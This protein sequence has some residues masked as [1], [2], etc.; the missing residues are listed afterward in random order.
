MVM[1]T[2]PF[3]GLYGQK[4]GEEREEGEEREIY[5]DNINEALT[6][7]IVLLQSQL[8]CVNQYVVCGQPE[9]SPAHAYNYL[10]KPISMY[11]FPCSE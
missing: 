2:S 6:L 4:K 11:I 1:H 5:D 10:S 8:P 9:A 3:L 7:V